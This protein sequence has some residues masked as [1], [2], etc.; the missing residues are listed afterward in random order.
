[1]ASGPAETE[2]QQPADS[3]THTVREQTRQPDQQDLRRSGSE[4]ELL[5]AEEQSLIAQAQAGNLQALRPIF[6][7]YSAPLLS[8]VILPRLGNRAA[9]E[10]VL[11]D[12]FLT[13]LEKLGQFRWEGHGFYPW[14]RQ[15]TV[16]KVMDVHRRA[17]RAARLADAIEREPMPVPT[18]AEEALAA[19]AEKKRNF[20]QLQSVLERVN[21]RYRRA[22]ELVRGEFAERTWQAFWRTTVDGQVPRDVGAELGMSPGAVRVAKSRVLQRLREELGDLI[23]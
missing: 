23:D 15:V 21:P 3:A 9:A 20:Q 18:G 2:G 11:R 10:D 19:E 13:A 8:G 6:E 5:L 12:T 22:L 7:R 16:N 1:M 4:G 17:R 14:L